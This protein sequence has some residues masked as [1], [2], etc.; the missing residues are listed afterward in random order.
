[1]EGYDEELQGYPA[2]YREPRRFPEYDTGYFDNPL[3]IVANCVIT[4]Y[5]EFNRRIY[6]NGRGFN[7]TM[8]VEKARDAFTEYGFLSAENA[9][10]IFACAVAITI[11]R[12]ILDF[13]IFKRL[14]VMLEV[15]K[16][17]AVKMPESCW[18]GFAYTCTWIWAV[19]IMFT[20][21]NL[22][23][24]PDS[25][26]SDWKPGIPITSDVYWL[27]MIQMGFYLHCVYATLFIETRRKDF[28][29]LMIHH[30][31]TLSLL[32]F[33]L[34][35]RFQKIGLM[36]LFLHD[37]GD[38]MLEV[39][40]SVVYCKFRGKHERPYIE[41]AANIL[42]LLFTAQWIFFRLYWFPIKVLYSSATVSV[43]VYPGGPFYIPFNIMLTIL[44][45]MQIYWFA[46]II[47]LIV[48]VMLGGKVEDIREDSEEVD[49]KKDDGDKN[50]P[51]TAAGSKESDG[52][53]K[54]TNGTP[55]TRKR[56]NKAG[57]S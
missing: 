12:Y 20:R 8:L 48:R 44:Y 43:V 1:M 25:H 45:I 24:N 57:T 51:V 38:V 11:L 30:F 3:P 32:L 56:K 50:P 40:K 31:L 54:A 36:V 55:K 21:P 7:G 16:E 4:F 46:F 28:L 6:D 27:Y 26:W 35:V 19:Y 42:F 29:V 9:I 39:S 33:S 13:V 10:H 18:K 34:A 23:F 22:F 41:T 53:G 2:D 15:N 14:P 5:R 37:I 49:K 47:A 52:V 17:N